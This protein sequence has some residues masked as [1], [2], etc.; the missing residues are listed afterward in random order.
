ML[1]ALPLVSALLEL[2]Q[3]PPDTSMSESA[4]RLKSPAAAT[5]T[6]PPLTTVGAVPG[7]TVTLG[8]SLTQSPRTSI[9][10]PAPKV[11]A[12]GRPSLPLEV[13]K[14]TRPP[15]MWMLPS[16]SIDRLESSESAPVGARLTLVPAG[17]ATAPLLETLI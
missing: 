2:I 12:C 16:M 13:C 5:L 9:T 3:P 11:M 8:E 4:A 14:A 10:A 1:P 15:A 6:L 17:S 7:V